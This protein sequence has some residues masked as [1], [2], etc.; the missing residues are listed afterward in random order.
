MIVQVHIIVDIKYMWCIRMLNGCGGGGLAISI[1]VAVG[2][3]KDNGTARPVVVAV[4]LMLLLL[5]VILSPL[6]LLFN[7]YSI[8]SFIHLFIIQLHLL[9][10]ILSQVILNH[11]YI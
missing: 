8:H 7:S 6:S 2:G 9:T 3:G 11:M 10:I 5:Y 4:V 1:A